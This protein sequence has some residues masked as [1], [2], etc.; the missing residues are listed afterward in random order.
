MSDAAR[1]LRPALEWLLGSHSDLTAWVCA[2]DGIAVI[3]HDFLVEKGLSVPGDVSL[4]GFDDSA[5]SFYRGLTS[6]NFNSR[7]VAQALL[8]HLLDRGR[9]R[10]LW[11]Q[12]T[13]VTIEGFVHD[14]RSVSVRALHA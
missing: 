12:R 6:Y 2:N 11:G 10:E 5:D 13:D 8:T 7:G 3:A 1:R 9:S 14:R 4:V